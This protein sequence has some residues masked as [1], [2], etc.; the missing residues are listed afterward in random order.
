MF[1]F[2]LSQLFLPFKLHQRIKKKMWQEAKANDRKVRYKKIGIDRLHTFF[3]DFFY[4]ETD[5]GSHGRSQETGRTTSCLLQFQGKEE[6]TMHI[7]SLHKRSD[8]ECLGCSSQIGDPRQLL[9]II[10][11]NVKLYPNGEQYYFHENTNNLYVA[12]MHTFKVPLI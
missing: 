7:P 5:K 1:S 9:R 4:I 2:S 10:G 3:V 6:M 8:L 12:S 11:S